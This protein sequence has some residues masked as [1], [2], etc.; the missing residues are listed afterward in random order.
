MRTLENLY[1]IDSLTDLTVLFIADFSLLSH[2]IKANCPPTYS[3]DSEFLY[4]G[5]IFTK[6][7]NLSSD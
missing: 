3:L 4:I 6:N 1:K 5:N 7:P 2:I